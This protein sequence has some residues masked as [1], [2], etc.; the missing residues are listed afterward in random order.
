MKS[1]SSNTRPV[2]SFSGNCTDKVTGYV[3]FYLKQHVKVTKD[4]QDYTFLRCDMVKKKPGSL[5]KFQCLSI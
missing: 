4:F 1:C 2:S 5:S 3:K